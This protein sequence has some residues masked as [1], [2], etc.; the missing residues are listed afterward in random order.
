MST[1]SCLLARSSG[2]R[3]RAGPCKRSSHRFDDLGPDP[4]LSCLGGVTRVGPC[5]VY[6]ICRVYKDS[7]LGVHTM[8]PS[9]GL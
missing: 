2:G 4:L 5:F 6:G 1:T 9:Y 7:R 8:S 3:A